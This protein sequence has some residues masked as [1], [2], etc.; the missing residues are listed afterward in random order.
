[1]NEVILPALNEFL[2]QTDGNLTETLALSGALTRR[3]SRVFSGLLVMSGML[4][5]R[6]IKLLTGILNINGALTRQT[7]RALAG[8][9]SLS[10]A[11]TRETR[12][13]LAGSLTTRGH[14]GSVSRDLTGYRPLR[15]DHTRRRFEDLKTRTEFMIRSTKRRRESEGRLS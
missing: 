7:R 5:K 9:L 15:S 11:L 12:R 13:A 6:T 1:M 8:A 3:T 10:G 4:T 2:R 14:P